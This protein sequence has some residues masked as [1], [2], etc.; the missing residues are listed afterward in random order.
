MPWDGYYATLDGDDYIEDVILGRLTIGSLSKL[1]VVIEKIG[2]YEE[3]PLKAD[4]TWLLKA[5]LLI[6]KNTK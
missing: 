3:N 5:S 2:L 1:D 6:R 4:S